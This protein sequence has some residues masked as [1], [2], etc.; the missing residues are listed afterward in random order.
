M[1]K[2]RVAEHSPNYEKVKDFMIVNYGIKEKSG[3]R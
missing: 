3:M 1:A 2:K